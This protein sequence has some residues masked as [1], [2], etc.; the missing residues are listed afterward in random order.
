MPPDLSPPGRL[1]PEQKSAYRML[2][3]QGLLQIRILCF[4]SERPSPNPLRWRR[5]FYRSRL[6]VLIGDWLHNLAE[7]SARDFEGF[8]EDWFW[9]D[10]ERL[11]Q[12]WRQF[13]PGASVPFWATQEVQACRALRGSG[14]RGG[15]S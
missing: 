11:E 1:T 2:I 7:F 9:R 4:P 5:Q 10:T 12:R 6:V 13:N 15:R 14:E 8:D 3:Y